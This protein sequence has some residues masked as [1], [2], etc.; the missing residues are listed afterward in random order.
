MACHSPHDWKQH[1]A[2]ILPGMKGAGEPMPTQGLPGTV[3]A[4]NLTPDAETGA[5]NWTDDQLARAIREGIGHD[6]RTLFPIMPYQHFRELPD[7]DLASVIVFLRSLPPVKNP[8]PQTEIIFPVKYLIRGVPQPITAQVPA[9][10]LSTPVKRGAW[11][12]EMADCGECHTPREKGQPFPAMDFAGGGIFEG[13][14]GRVASANITPDASGI[15]YYDEALFL[16]TMRTGYVRTR[17]LTQIMPWSVYRNM[18]DEDLKAIF[19]YI[20]TVKP[21]AHRVDNTETAKYCPLCK[22]SHG[23]GDK[24]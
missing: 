3:F 16:Q 1:D 24:N 20:R 8:L 13:P 7:E 5:G 17:K 10:D 19:S 15:A 23:Y 11:L 21:I 6:G 4:P 14:W 9:P 18:T 22:A 2:P 12:A